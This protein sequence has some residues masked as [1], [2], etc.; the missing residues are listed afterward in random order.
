MSESNSNKRGSILGNGGIPSSQSGETVEVSVEHLGNEGIPT[1][2]V[3]GNGGIPSSSSGDQNDSS[4]GNKS[5][6]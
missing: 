5:K 3:T 2:K 4:K 1:C 6:G